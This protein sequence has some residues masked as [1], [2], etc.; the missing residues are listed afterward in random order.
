MSGE[1]RRAEALLGRVLPSWAV[2]LLL[3]EPRGLVAVVRW[4]RRRRPD[5]LLFPH[6][7]DVATILWTVV[8]SLVVE[9]VVV[10]VVLRVILGPSPW[11]WIALVLH[12]YAIFMIVAVYAA[13]LTR[14]HSL[15]GSELHLRSGLAAEVVVPADAI[16]VVDTG[17]F[18][19][20]DRSGWTVDADGN[21]TMASGEANLRLTLSQGS[22]VRVNGRDRTALSTIHLTV[23]EP[24]RLAAAI[25]AAR[26]GAPSDPGNGTVRS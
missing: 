23:D 17:R 24:R 15:R 9:G 10:D 19:D 20:F 12:V 4:A 22:T 26:D 1:F 7:R 25:A 14:P 21:A 5:G 16:D 8:A 18:P 2:A 13:M 11:V 3:A 6:H